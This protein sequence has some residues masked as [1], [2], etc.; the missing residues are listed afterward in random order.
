MSLNATQYEMNALKLLM[1][2]K[3][4]E[5]LSRMSPELF[6]TTELSSMYKLIALH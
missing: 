6:A 5:L 4:P 2:A 1:Q 3:S